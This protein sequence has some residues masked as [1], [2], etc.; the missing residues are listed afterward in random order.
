LSK[1]NQSKKDQKKRVNLINLVILACILVSILFWLAGSSEANTQYFAYSTENLLQG[2]WWTLITALFI[3]ADILHLAG[4]MLFLYAFGNSL[5]NE[6]GPAKTLLAFFVGGTLS[7]LLGTAGNF[8]E[9]SVYLVGASAAI[10]T[11]TAVVLLVKPL[12]FSFIFL[13]PLGLVAIIY[14]IYNVVAVQTGVE[15]NIAYISHVIG[16]AIGIPLGIAWSKNLLKNLLITIGLLLLYFFITIILLPYILQLLG[17][18][19]LPGILA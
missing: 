4:N 15:G 14:I 5:E 6:V 10:F 12:K 18:E 9:P 3:H 19:S 7:F 2:R 11:L 17:I 8:Y 16:F 13:M 1:N